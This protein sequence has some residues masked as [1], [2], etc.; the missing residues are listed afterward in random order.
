MQPIT[1]ADMLRFA[2]HAL[3]GYVDALV[4][5]WNRISAA[6]ITTPLRWAH[7]VAQI[8]HET[9]GF[10]I[11]RENCRWTPQQ[12]K[13]LWP[14][15]FPLGSADPRIVLAKGDERKLANLAYAAR[16]DIG[17]L[18][19][20]DGWRYRG[21]SFLQLTGRASYRECG[22]A[23]GIDLER[24]PELIEEQ[25]E[26]GL[27]AALWVWGRHPCNSFADHNYGRAI[28][29]AINRGNPYAKADPIGYAAR[30]QWLERAWAAWGAGPLPQEQ[31][32]CLG[33]SGPKV[34]ELQV[35]LRARGYGLGSADG[36][37]GPAT[38][39]AVAGFKLDARRAGV[40]Q[41]EPEEA[42][43]PLTLAALDAAPPAPLSPERTGATVAT[44]EEAGSTE[45]KAGKAAKVTGQTLLWGGAAAGAGAL[46]LLDQVNSALSS[47]NVLHMTMVPAIDA[48]K[49]GA[50]HFL[51]VGGIA[52]GIWVWAK[53]ADVIMA[54][55]QAYRSGANLGR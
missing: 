2:P 42:V 27:A 21:A 55:L 30:Q 37:M 18:G 54:R 8:A 50:Q 11:V 36:V 49:W 53:G 29:N 39:R 47:I 34:A 26:I 20:D 19:G 12:M 6:G 28:G 44:L 38:A 14:A 32:L 4:G 45:I 17:N 52:G 41:L 15:R 16:N 51:W 10:R 35:K 9:G 24:N 3:T 13:A 25:P 40:H 22:A 5:G 46:G 7:F 43:G 23:I 1:R 31:A 48:I 33:A